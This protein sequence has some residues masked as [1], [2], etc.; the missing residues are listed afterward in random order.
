L[1]DYDIQGS[2]AR[3][4]RRRGPSLPPITLIAAFETDSR[5]TRSFQMRIPEATSHVVVDTPAAITAAEISSL[6]HAA[7]KIIVPVLP[8]DIDSHAASRCIANL[9]LVAKVKRDENRLAVVANRVKRN[10]LAYHSLLRFLETLEI[11][12]I[13]TIRDSQNYARSAELSLGL[14]EMKPYQVSADLEQWEQLL[15]WLASPTM[16]RAPPGPLPGP[17]ALSV[18][19]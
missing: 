17:L 19:C 1:I 11:P 3:W 13:A 2:S 10:T 12:V 18:A 15:S 6:T 4:V 16:H 7:D 9:L 8:S 5:T 14:H